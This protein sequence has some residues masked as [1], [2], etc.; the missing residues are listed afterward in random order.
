MLMSVLRSASICILVV[1]L[2]SAGC[3]RPNDKPKQQQ[4]AINNKYTLGQVIS[5]G[6]GGKS[7]AYKGVGW[8]EAEP[9]MTWTNARVARLAFRLPAVDKPLR[10]RMRL[11]GFTNPPALTHQPVD[12]VVNDEMVAQ[13]QVSDL[14]DFIAIIPADVANHEQLIVELRIPEAVSPKVLDVS[15]DSR[16]LGV[17][18]HELAI[19]AAEADEERSAA[20]LPPGHESSHSKTYRLGTVLNLGLSGGAQR[21]KGPGWYPP[22]RHFV[23]TARG[24]AVLE[25]D[26]PPRERPL[27]LKMR[28]AGLTH[29]E[30]LPAQPTEIYANG[31]KIAERLVAAPAEHEILIPE[32]ALKEDGRLRLELRAPTA[33][34]PRVLG[35]N[36]DSRVLGVQVHDLVITEAA[37]EA[38]GTSPPAKTAAK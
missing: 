11:N 36:N 30:L 14:A 37:N 26:L 27:R 24:P 12:V 6:R 34:T 23:W 5:F 21:Y 31:S 2:L 28:L 33:T 20:R 3:G 22:E 7:L 16:M 38:S 25:F 35:L 4:R 17:A 29:P 10:L 15:E 32:R 19:T 8:G 18:C 9:G 1:A 13:W